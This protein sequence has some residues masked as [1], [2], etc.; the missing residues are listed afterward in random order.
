MLSFDKIVN[1]MLKNCWKIY[2]KEDI[3][4]IIDPEKKIS[5]RII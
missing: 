4:E 2:F 1:K 3:F 5:I